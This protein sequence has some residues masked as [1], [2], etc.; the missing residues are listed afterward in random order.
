MLVEERSSIWINLHNL[1]HG[2]SSSFRPHGHQESDDI[3]NG[4][5]YFLWGSERSGFCQ[6]YMYYFNPSLETAICQRGG[7][8]I[9]T[10]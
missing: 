10:L 8:P 6:L 1:C 7:R 4:E 5:F 3:N 9:G 2:F